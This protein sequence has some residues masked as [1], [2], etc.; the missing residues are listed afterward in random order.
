MASSRVVASDQTGPEWVRTLK[1]PLRPG[2]SCYIGSVT[3]TATREA[4]LDE[5]WKSALVDIARRDFPELVKISEKSK[6]SLHDAEYLRNTVLEG[7]KIRF[8]GV[9]EES[10]SPYIEPHRSGGFSAYRLLCWSKADL[11]AEKARQL[12][13]EKSRVAAPS[14]KVDEVL[15]LGLQPTGL[16]GRLEIV[17]IPAGATILLQSRPVG[18]S[19]AAFEKVIPGSYDVWLQKDGYEIRREAIL[20]T[21]GKT[22]KVNASLVRAQAK[23]FVNSKPHG[24]RILV[25]NK[26]TG[27]K[28]PA[29]VMEDVGNKVEVRVE[30]D[31]YN[32]ERRI[33]DVGSSSP[34]ISFDLN[35]YQGRL[36]VL[37]EIPMRGAKI[38]LN[39]QYVGESPLF[40]QTFPGGQYALR[41]SADGYHDFLSNIDIRGSRPL[42]VT[43][44]LE[45][46]PPA[47]EY[48]PTPE[49]TVT[50]EATP[51]PT[52][53]STQAPVQVK[54]Q[55]LKKK[56][57]A[58]LCKPKRN[59]DSVGA[60]LGDAIEGAGSVIEE[61]SGL[62]GIGR[63][64]MK[65][66]VLTDCIPDV[67]GK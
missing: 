18:V 11:D 21:E 24:A 51:V 26:P 39:N 56:K 63:V 61:E 14:S 59:D 42:T 31:D 6:E 17:T 62:R 15:P 41:I 32:P 33:V 34:N 35:M 66:R 55:Q 12:A 19:N 46:L 5:S 40:G 58:S 49:P 47:S 23:L 48:T 13:E 1:P 7:D 2:K 27:M 3:Q 52:P 29:Q 38:Y 8:R 10:D 45:A 57:S 67:P 9:Q 30:M 4:A 43:T 65:A 16:L 36:S 50:S 25:D 22:T 53:V 44:R 37:T 60:L 64:S 28:T 20:V 54:Q